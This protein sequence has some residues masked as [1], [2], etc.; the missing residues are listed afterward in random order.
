M[1]GFIL[2][3]IGTNIMKA[4]KLGLNS[5]GAFNEGLTVITGISFGRINQMIGLI[6]ITGKP[7]SY[8]RTII[9]ATVLVLG[10]LLGGTFGIGTIVNTFLGGPLLG[11]IYKFF[12]FDPKKINQINLFSLNKQSA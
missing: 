10:I 7:V 11:A 4:S 5:W 3:A 2:I 8:I 6:K 1:M 9:E 12:K